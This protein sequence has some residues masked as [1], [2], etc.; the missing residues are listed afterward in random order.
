LGEKF[1]CGAFVVPDRSPKRG[2]IDMECFQMQ[3]LTGKTRRFSE[4]S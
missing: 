4:D 2:Q 1:P 3:Q